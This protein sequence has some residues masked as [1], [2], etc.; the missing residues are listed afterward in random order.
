MSKEHKSNHEIKAIEANLQNLQLQPSG[1]DR[2]ELM[3]KSG[4][5]AAM[6]SLDAKG[7]SQAPVPG[8][9]RQTGVVWPAIAIIASTAGTG[10][11]LAVFWP[12]VR[13]QKLQRD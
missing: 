8:V 3:Y 7:S 9:A 13:F 6:A 4:W 10:F 1:I 2:D 12:D 11:L 5:A